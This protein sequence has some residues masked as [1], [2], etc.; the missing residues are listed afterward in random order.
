M[1]SDRTYT[2][3]PTGKSREQ[4]CHC[5]R[6]PYEEKAYRGPAHKESVQRKIL[7][8]VVLPSCPV[9][10]LIVLPCCGP[11]CV[12]F[13]PLVLPVFPPSWSSLYLLFP[14][15]GPSC[16]P[17]NPSF[18]CW[19]LWSFLPVPLSLGPSL[20]RCFC[21]FGSFSVCCFPPLLVLRWPPVFALLFL[22]SA[23]PAA[24]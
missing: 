15:F 16:V 1:L 23:V 22:V 6:N 12:L 3:A 20:L 7:A 21:L 11:S 4:G 2:V 17:F 24:F 8:F 14:P 9:L 18:V 19:S 10:A 5:Q 13:P